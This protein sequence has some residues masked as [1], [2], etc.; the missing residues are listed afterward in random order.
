LP[1]LLLLGGLGL[2]LGG[3]VPDVDGG[4]DCV[5]QFT[6]ASITDPSGHVLVIGGER[7]FEV[8]VLVF[9][10]LLPL[11]KCSSLLPSMTDLFLCLQ[12]GIRFICYFCDILQCPSHHT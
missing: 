3:G 7:K 9:L 8:N 6:L 5:G 11:G 4:V 1:L 12:Y 2:L 10:P